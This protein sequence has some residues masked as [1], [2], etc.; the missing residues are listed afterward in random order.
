MTLTWH[1]LD[2]LP[3]LAAA[4]MTRH[5]WAFSPAWFRTLAGAVLRR[6]ERARLAWW[7]AG[8]RGAGI[9]L[10]LGRA[11]RLR[12]AQEAHGMTDLYTTLYGPV[13]TDP[14]AA[15]ELGRALGSEPLDLIEINALDPHCPL[16][17][18]LAAGL[19]A[20]RWGVIHYDHF[21]NWHAVTDGMDGTGFLASRTA[22][23]RNTCARKERA[24][25]RDGRLETTLVR[26]GAE[27]AQAIAD[28]EEVH[29]QSWKPPEPHPTFI[30]TLIRAMAEA[31]FLRL[32][33]ARIDGRPAA[34]QI[35]LVAQGRATIFKLCH[36]IAVDR[37]SVGSVLTACMA[38][39]VL[40]EG[41]VR[42]IDFGR[43][44]DSY[45]QLWMPT[46]RQ[47]IGL[48]AANPARPLGVALL[49]RHVW[50]PGL[51][52]RRRLGESA[53]V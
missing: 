16:S 40:G 2:A 48:L 22:S 23:L 30:A 49:A 12:G 15:A 4:V 14:A 47:R 46:R 21:G 39:A 19:V 44:D 53:A 37:L 33:L 52:Q 27:V 31:G 28:Y 8:D 26:S 3:P 38:T 42:E 11:N 18:A 50:L 29:A 6:G 45:K 9:V 13:A 17:T 41:G 1:K 36:A 5:G 43:G 35:W 20:Q 34:A 24:L 7:Q 51:R 10:R 25:R 32:G